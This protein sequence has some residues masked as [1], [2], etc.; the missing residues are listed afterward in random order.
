MIKTLRK[1]RTTP[2][3]LITLTSV[4]SYLNSRQQNRPVLPSHTRTPTQIV[5]LFF[6]IDEQLQHTKFTGLFVKF[7]PGTVMGWGTEGVR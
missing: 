3:K 4:L 1:Q 7:Q 6:H 5:L 2:T